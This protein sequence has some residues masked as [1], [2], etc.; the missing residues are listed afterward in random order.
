MSRYYKFAGESCV[1][2]IS[3]VLNS[4]TFDFFFEISLD[5]L[6]FVLVYVVVFFSLLLIY[7]SMIYFAMWHLP[8]KNV[9][10]DYPTYDHSRTVC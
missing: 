2:P 10:V 1:R 8:F 5:S 3:F 9:H 4:V 7:L 6:L